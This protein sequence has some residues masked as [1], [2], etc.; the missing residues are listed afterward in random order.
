MCFGKLDLF[1]VF[2]PPFL[3]PFPGAPVL[4]LLNEAQELHLIAKD[5]ACQEIRLGIEKMTLL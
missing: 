3:F 5:E 1:S 4:L 2:S